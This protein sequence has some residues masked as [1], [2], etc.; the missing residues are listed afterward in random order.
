MSHNHSSDNSIQIKKITW[1]GMIANIILSAVKFI[2]GYL[3]SS[4][5][6]IADAVHSLSDMSTDI[7]VLLGLKFW[8]AP[9]DEGHPYGHGRIEAL[10]TL[11]IGISLFAVAIGIGYNSVTTIKEAH[12][13][14]VTLIAITG[15]ALS[16]MVKEILYRWTVAVGRRVKS[17]A[18]VANAWHHRSDA[19]S[20]IPALIA[21]AAAA[22]NPEWEF[23][24]HIG[25]LII[26]IFILKVSWDIVSP[27]LSELIDTSAS[28]KETERIERIAMSINGVKSVHAIR[29]RK[30]GSSIQ[31]DLHVLV[32]GNIPV[33]LGHDISEQVKKQL[34]KDGPEVIDVVVHIEPEE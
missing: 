30:F 26:S 33:W 9:P 10:V 4:Q 27:A 5:A 1:A 34:L 32:D 12:D 14:P 2:V 7:A 8:S 13:H 18:V 17:S 3:G 29:T 25:A 23:I 6:V 28:Q 22:I 24:D 15:P 20:S 31:V 11:A 19:F 21:V 16:I